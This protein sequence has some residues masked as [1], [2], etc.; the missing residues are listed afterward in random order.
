MLIR[1]N[2]HKTLLSIACFCAFGFALTS[3]YAHSVLQEFPNSADEY[4]YV[5]QAD[6]F[7]AGRLWNPT[8]ARPLQEFFQFN[9]V[10]QRDGKWLQKLCVCNWFQSLGRRTSARCSPHD[11]SPSP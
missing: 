11:L 10:A 2:R 4:A 6:T 7:G 8:L 9:H 5:F 1:H 3:I